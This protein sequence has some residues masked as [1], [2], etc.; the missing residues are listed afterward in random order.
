MQFSH[1]CLFLHSL[2]L[3]QGPHLGPSSLTLTWCSHPPLW[4]Q[5]SSPC[6]HDLSAFL[7]TRYLIP[8]AFSAYSCKYLTTITHSVLDLRNLSFLHSLKHSRYVL[9]IIHD[10]SLFLIPHLQSGTIHHSTTAVFFHHSLFLHL[11]YLTSGSH[12]FSPRSVSV[13]WTLRP[14][15][16]AQGPA[17]SLVH[18]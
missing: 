7:S 16:P 12:P 18:L 17:P 6:P 3:S 14:A 10:S 15:M 2:L 4:T 9:G 11:R 1:C 13:L 5:L 8:S